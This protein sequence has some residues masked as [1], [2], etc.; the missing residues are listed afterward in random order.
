MTT[1]RSCSNPS[2]YQCTTE[3]ILQDLVHACVYLDDILVTGESET[4]HLHNFSVVLERL[5]AAGVHFK[6]EKCSFMLK[7]M[8]Y[9]GHHISARGL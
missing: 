8:E 4:A 9:L 1:V 6:R 7:E 2:H 5:E 3:A